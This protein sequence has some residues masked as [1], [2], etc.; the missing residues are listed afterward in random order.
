MSYINNMLRGG[1]QP[2][3][4]MGDYENDPVALLCAE[5]IIHEIVDWRVLIKS[6][7]WL[8][9]HPSPYCNFDELRLFFKSEWCDFLMQD[10]ELEPAC[11]FEI[12]EAELEEAKRRL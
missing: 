11:I 5:I 8:N 2:A 3:G 4:Y 6:R 10:F 9:K 7:E 12:L 1:R